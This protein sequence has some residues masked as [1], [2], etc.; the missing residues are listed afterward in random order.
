[1][2]RVTEKHHLQTTIPFPFFAL[3][4][5]WRDKK[6]VNFHQKRLAMKDKTW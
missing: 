3:L 2:L 5:P 6:P 4:A 1:V